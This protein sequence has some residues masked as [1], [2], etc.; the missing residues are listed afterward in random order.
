MKIFTNKKVW[1][2]IV[3]VMLILLLM[4]FFIGKPVHALPGDTLL[5]PVTSLFANLGDGIMEI[6]QKTIMGMDSSGAWIEK[7][8]GLWAKIAIIGLAILAA[9]VAV[10]AIVLSGGAALT[11]VATA[12][13]AVLK[14]AGIAIVVYFAASV[15]HFGEERILFAR[16]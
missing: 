8:N 14:I 10:A 6:M 1:Q 9:C 4:Q 2:K 11:I 16:F 3:L 15:T 12:A 5:E 13:G 7:D